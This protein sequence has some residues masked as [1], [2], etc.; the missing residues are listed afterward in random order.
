M[1]R[2]LA[3]L[4]LSC[5][6]LVSCSSAPTAPRAATLDFT[7]DAADRYV[8]RWSSPSESYL[9][10]LR[11]QYGLDAVVSG[12]RSDFER[13]RL[14]SRWVRGRWE[15]N[16]DNVAD[17]GDPLSILQGAARGQRFRCVE[18]AVVLSG[19]L[20][21]LGIPARVLGLKTQDVETRATGAGHVVAEAYLRDQ[22]KWVLVDGQWDAI[23]MLGGVPLNAVELQRALARRERGLGV[24]SISRT[25]A[26]AYFAWTAPYLY[27]FDAALDQRVGVR[28][29][30]GALMLVP[31]G[32]KNPTV[33]QQKYPMG[34]MT[35]THNVDAF[36]A[37]P[38][39]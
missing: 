33:F 1:R 19:A 26:A 36:Y 37:P 14:V 34:V 38:A 21:A 2:I 28:T 10:T 9:T 7:Q 27:Y 24:T 6:A 18:Y 23:P 11:T 30:A 5:A 39:P 25:D 35:Y 31:V 8:T 4:A 12:A 29:Q 13:V 17:P 16:G 32:A 20:N 15:H 3:L 22:G